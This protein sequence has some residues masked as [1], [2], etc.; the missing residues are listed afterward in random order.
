MS[1]SDPLV[2]AHW[3]REVLSWFDTWQD[4]P[5][6]MPSGRRRS[7]GRLLRACLGLVEFARADGKLKG[8]HADYWSIK[9]LAP[10]M[11]TSERTAPDI[12]AWLEQSGRM[13]KARGAWTEYGRGT[14]MRCLVCVET[15]TATLNS[16]VAVTQT[17]T[18]GGANGNATLEPN[19]NATLSANGNVE[20]DPCRTRSF[21]SLPKHSLAVN[22]GKPTDELVTA[23][24][25]QS[26][27]HASTRDLAELKNWEEE[28]GYRVSVPDMIT[29]LG[30]VWSRAV[31]SGVTP[32]HPQYFR[33]EIRERFEQTPH[34]RSGNGATTPARPYV[35]PR[36][37]GEPP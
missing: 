22:V 37:I 25:Q 8:T 32:E 31:A 12:L 15:Q 2:A 30:E 28:F 3:R 4:E 9:Q 36:G 24:C 17:A 27:R 33:R 29:T 11:A 7:A 35:V 19:G 6:L 23:W 13:S 16:T 34:T 18:I 10:M 5:Q 1:G 14:D 26:G 20:I 21:R